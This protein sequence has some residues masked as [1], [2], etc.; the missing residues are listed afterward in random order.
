MSMT[1]K[2][3]TRLVTKAEKKLREAAE[4][5]SDLQMMAMEY[6]VETDREQRFASELRERAQYWEQCTWWQQEPEPRR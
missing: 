3:K 4:A 2:Q 1:I 5:L 6:G